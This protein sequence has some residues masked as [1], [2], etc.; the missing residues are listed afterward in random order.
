MAG[1]ASNGIE[2]VPAIVHGGR[3]CGLSIYTACR[4]GLIKEAHETRKGHNVGRAVAVVVAVVVAK[5]SVILSESVGRAFR[6][7]FPFIREIL[8]S[9]THLD[10]VG[11][12]GEDE[13]RFVLCFPSETSHCSVVTVRVHMS[14]YPKVAL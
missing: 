5:V 3:A 8:I 2:Q 13:K 4:H 1:H 12:A 6:I 7:L 10:V 11:L 14:H 9:D